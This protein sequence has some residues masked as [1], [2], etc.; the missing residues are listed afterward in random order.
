MACHSFKKLRNSSWE[1]NYLKLLWNEVLGSFLDLPQ[2]FTFLHLFPWISIQVQWYATNT[3]TQTH[4]LNCSLVWCSAL[5]MQD[6]SLPQKCYFLCLQ[7]RLI[8]GRQYWASFAVLTRVWFCNSHSDHTANRTPVSHLPEKQIPHQ[9]QLEIT[10]HRYKLL[11]FSQSTSV[12]C[13]GHFLVVETI[14][15]WLLFRI[16]SVLVWRTS[17]ASTA[18]EWPRF[19]CFSFLLFASASA[20]NYT[21]NC[22]N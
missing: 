1:K 6:V 19:C 11:K 20:V 4:T 7:P 10:V 18:A 5:S 16:L 14:C 8:R 12:I 3:Q 13:N 2:V 22:F 21:F 9:L 15:E 17:V